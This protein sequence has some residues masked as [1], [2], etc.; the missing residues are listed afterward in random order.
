V[1]SGSF[2]S[3]TNWVQGVV[4]GANDVAEFTTSGATVT[5]LPITAVVLGL[6]VVSTGILA[7]QGHLTATE[8]TAAWA[9]HGTIDISGRP[10]LGGTVNNIGTI[11]AS[12][13]AGLNFQSF[14]ATLMGSGTVNLD[15]AFLSVKDLNKLTNIDNTIQGH[16][17]IVDGTPLINQKNG[18]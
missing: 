3:A 13:N 7:V 12:S 8:G 5:V 2:T 1:T 15:G 17:T 16:G 10:D 14:D 4:P 18:V 9:H 6:N 11:N